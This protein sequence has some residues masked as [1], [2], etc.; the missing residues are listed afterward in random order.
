[1]LSGNQKWYRVSLRLMGD[2]L[3]VDEVEA[4]LGFAPST[5]GRKGEH[6]RGDPRF[7]KHATNG[8]TL[9]DFTDSDVPFEQQITVL[10]DMLE[11]N[12]DALKQILSLPDVRGE[13]F[14][15]FSSG[16]G[17]GGA[18]FPPALLKRIAENG[19]SLNLD[20][21]PPDIDEGKE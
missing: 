18:Q 5:F 8:W 21:Y 7:A 16:N 1:M 10:L 9:G 11:P 2:G 15:G 20:L 4:R 12:I 6:L 19:L 14:L 17:Q 3:P 13:L